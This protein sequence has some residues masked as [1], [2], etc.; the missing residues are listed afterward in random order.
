MDPKI[1][2]EIKR[3]CPTTEKSIHADLLLMKNKFVPLFDKVVPYHPTMTYGEMFYMEEYGNQPCILDWIVAH[4]NK[5]GDP[6]GNSKKI[7]CGAI[8]KEIQQHHFQHIMDA[9]EHF[10]K[11][12]PKYYI[13]RLNVPFPIHD[14]P[15]AQGFAFPSGHSIHGLLFGAILYR[16]NKALFANN[17]GELKD[18]A[19]KCFDVGMRRIIGGV[20]YPSDIVGAFHFVKYVTKDW[21]IE[22]LMHHYQN[23]LLRF[24]S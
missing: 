2:D 3:F 13:K 11:L 1:I 19:N 12:R 7:K 4:Y 10:K 9:K 6:K 21:K 14:V 23:R 22:K 17:T 15:S 16:D 8:M 20:H 24:T 18:L 5:M